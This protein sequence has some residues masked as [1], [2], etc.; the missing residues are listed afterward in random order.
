MFYPPLMEA[1]RRVTGPTTVDAPDAELLARFV[2]SRD[3]AAF[4]A[5][6]RRHGGLVWGACRRRLRDA[7][8]AED[9]FQTTFLALARHAASVRRP[10]ALGGWLHRVA[11]RCSAGFRPPRESMSPPPTDLPARGPEPVTAVAGRELERVID[12]EIDRL[13][14]PFRQAFVM[15]EVE[16]RTSS[17]AARALGCPVG[18]VESRLTRA[19]ER[20]RARLARRG[21]T[22]GALAGLGLAAGSVPASA[23]AGAVAL[24]VGT[25]PVPVG[26]SALA[27]RAARAVSGLTVTTSLIGTVALVGLGGLVWAFGQGQI[28]RPGT[29]TAI[30]ARIAPDDA[31]PE[32]DQFRRNRFN[33]PLP[34][35]A[36]SRVGDPWLRHGSVPLRLAFSGDGRFLA[37][38]GAND[39]WLRVWDLTT[40]RPRMHFPLAPGEVPA[41][42]A[43]SPD[44][45]TLR[46][47]IHTRDDR[48]AH[49]REYDTYRVNET[50]R[51]TLAGGLATTAVFDA[52]G[53]RLLE[54]RDGFVRLLDTVS[55][56]EV[57]RTPVPPGTNVDL[58]L[59]SAGRAAII[60]AGSDR[61]RV[62]DLATGRPE[63]ELVEAG[64]RLSL[65]ALSADGRR[66]AA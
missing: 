29:T 19:R 23:R 15:C 21:I 55:T 18:T 13:P 56:K 1:L 20:L 57:W 16:Q 47:V 4:A 61:I 42:L 49:L 14:E 32:P 50:R 9:A 65:P 26:W 30:A 3:E 35:E 44:G 11:V 2:H 48:T 34:P 27:D 52:D 54:A 5:L 17:D 66:V 43:L 12:A 10:D 8:A 62:V 28:A 22:V 60:P 38:A 36:I 59:C 7:H 37:A 41:A 63:G 25:S 24:A 31:I 39:R 53:S 6:V 40:G 46:A 33:F 58:A 45:A 64:T 51:R